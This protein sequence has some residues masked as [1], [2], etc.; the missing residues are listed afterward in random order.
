MILKTV[1]QLRISKWTSQNKPIEHVRNGR[2]LTR[3]PLHCIVS[4]RHSFR[5]SQFK[6]LR[7]FILFRIPA[8]FAHPVRIDGTKSKS[9]G[10]VCLGGKLS[11]W[12]M[13][14]EFVSSPRMRQPFQ[15]C[16]YLGVQSLVLIQSCN[17]HAIRANVNK[18]SDARALCH[19]TAFIFVTYDSQIT[20]GKQIGNKKQTL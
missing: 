19:N 16:Y 3:S 2:R 4:T 18:P 20:H 12:V 17:R 11:I 5:F 13:A 15:S 8:I 10:L 14:V 7:T 6:G 9:H 1:P